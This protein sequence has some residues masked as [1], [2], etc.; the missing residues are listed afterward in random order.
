M[1]DLRELFGDQQK[2]VKLF[3][4][5]IW[6]SWTVAVF[7]TTGQNVIINLMHSWLHN[8]GIGSPSVAT[9]NHFADSFGVSGPVI[10][11][12]FFW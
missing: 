11:P 2:N 7:H 6:F 10:T 9:C 5:V 8:G 1:A 4:W 3:Q 12:T